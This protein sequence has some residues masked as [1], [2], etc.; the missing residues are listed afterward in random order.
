MKLTYIIM[1]HK[2][3]S[4]FQRLI[5]RL[6]EPETTFIFHIS[7]ACEPGFYEQASAIYEGQDNI[8]FAPRTSIYW[9]D[10][11]MVQASLHCIRTL[12]E[13]NF[14]YEY[15]VFLSGQDYPLQPREGI[16]QAL[17]AGNGGQFMEFFTRDE[18]YPDTF[19][20]LYGHHLWIRG[21]HLW[22]PHRATPSLKTRL[23]D[24][25]LSLF[26]PRVRTLPDGCTGYKGSF[27]WM[28]TPDCIAYIDRFTRTPAG[29]HL[30]RY[31]KYTYHPSEYFYQTLLMNS[32]YKTQVINTDHHF[33]KWN[34]ESGHPKNL[35]ME[36]FDELLATPMLFGR[37]FDLAYDAAVL[38]AL[39]AANEQ[40]RRQYQHLH[41][42]PHPQPVPLAAT[43]PAQNTD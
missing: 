41:A 13:S 8:R 29:E 6:N 18:F 39:D 10:F 23:F 14:H 27:W 19:H 24:G 7:S 22:F 36:D 38:D 3:F 1:A 15:A 42:H 32:A 34:D 2:N 16:N 20:R 12:L 25:V 40:K 26:L 35:G 30:K 43:H 37:K 33:A 28:L 4:Q 21:R 5:D 31:L 11:S 9:G 17:A